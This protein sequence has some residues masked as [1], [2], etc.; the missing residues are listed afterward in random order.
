MMMIVFIF[1]FGLATTSADPED[2]PTY[3]MHELCGKIINL[4]RESAFSAKIEIL[5]AAIFHEQTK[6]E[7]TIEGLDHINIEHCTLSIESWSFQNRLMVHF[8]E[9]KLNADGRCLDS[10]LDILDGPTEMSPRITGYPNS[11]VHAG[12]LMS[13]SFETTDKHM[14]LRFHGN[15]TLNNNAVIKAVVVS[16]NGGTCRSYEH[17]CFNGRCIMNDLVCNGHNPCGD[18]SDCPTTATLPQE[19][20]K[21][22][23]VMLVVAVAS[24]ATLLILAVI[25]GVLFI[26]Y[27]SRHKNRNLHHRNEYQVVNSTSR[28]HEPVSVSQPTYERTISQIE[29]ERRYAPPSYSQLPVIENQTEIEAEE[30]LTEPKET[31]TNEISFVKCDELDDNNPPS[32]SR[33]MLCKDAYNVSENNINVLTTERT[34]S[35]VSFDIGG[36]SDSHDIDSHSTKT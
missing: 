30:T 35:A 19:I 3:Y 34:D 21:K 18:N 24:S 29:A 36:E 16:F 27:R 8:E 6:P 25:V 22:D 2:I 23:H 13:R 12:N 11:C 4:R 32:Y 20:D 31:L 15:G 7:V 5:P 33:V 28:G 9:V 10:N 26:C 1:L 14:T 17:Q